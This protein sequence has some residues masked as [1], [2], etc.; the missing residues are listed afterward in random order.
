VLQRQNGGS[1]CTVATHL[2]T[3]GR[4][5][6]SGSLAPKCG[7]CRGR[8]CGRSMGGVPGQC[9]PIIS[10]V[11]WASGQTGHVQQLRS[12]SPPSTEI[13]VSSTTKSTMRGCERGGAV[14]R[15]AGER[16]H[17]QRGAA[18]GKGRVRSGRRVR[19]RRGYEQQRRAVQHRRRFLSWQCR[20]PVL[21][22]TTGTGDRRWRGRRTRRCC[23]RSRRGW[24]GRRGWSA[25]EWR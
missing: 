24:P 7:L 25:L 9:V 17:H 19:I 15:C 10:R 4:D 20:L 23:C 11:G 18:T 22:C 16:A 2:I 13:S 14:V 6:G 12:G 3:V 21:H 8:P 5:A 1:R